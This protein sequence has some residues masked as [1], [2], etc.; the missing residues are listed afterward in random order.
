MSAMRKT[1][2]VVAVLAWALWMGGF[3]FFTAVSLRVAHRVL[4]DPG[5]FGFV[6]QTVTDR[7]NIIGLVAVVLLLAQL[8]SHW[9]ILASRPRFAM[10]CTWLTLA[11]TL[12]LMFLQHN[13]IDGLLDFQQR[14]V[15]DRD[16][17]ERVHDRYEMTA[18]IQ[19]LAAVVHLAVMLTVA[20]VR[21]PIA[22]GDVDGR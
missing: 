1:I 18:T 14:L 19:W 8:T 5:D 17:F 15:T 12:G 21:S 2:H 3:T 4:D 10:T 7:L 11:I 16:A 20:G 22:A 13:Q 6:T 9:R